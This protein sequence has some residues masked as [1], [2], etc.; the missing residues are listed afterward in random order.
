MLHTFKLMLL[1]SLC[2]QEVMGESIAKKLLGGITNGHQQ[3]TDFEISWQE[4]LRG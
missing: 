4:G 3:K 2:W 1:M